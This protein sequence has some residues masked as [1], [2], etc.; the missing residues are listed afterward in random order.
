MPYGTALPPTSVA[1]SANGAVLV[2]GER[3]GERVHGEVAM[4]PDGTALPPHSVALSQ[5]M[6]RCWW[7]VRIPLGVG[8]AAAL[9]LAP[10]PSTPF[11]TL[12]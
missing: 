11:H 9:L 10:H 8:I 4:T 12:R 5:P 7:P 1:L 6:A 3:T 2:A